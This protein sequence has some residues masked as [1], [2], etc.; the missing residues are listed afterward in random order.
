MVKKLNNCYR[1]EE[2]LLFYKDKKTAEKC[3]AWCR[4]NSSCNIEITKYSIKPKIDGGKNE[5]S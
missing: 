3:G 2:C 1:C 5:K 4:N